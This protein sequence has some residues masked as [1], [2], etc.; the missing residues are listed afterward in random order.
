[1]MDLRERE[2]VEWRENVVAGVGRDPAE[3]DLT[4]L[5]HLSGSVG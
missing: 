4:L 2:Q 1:M 5:Q 3:D